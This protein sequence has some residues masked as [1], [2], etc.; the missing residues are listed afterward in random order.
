MTK[1]EIKRNMAAVANAIANQRLEGVEPSRA[2]VFDLTRAAHGEIPV[3]VV[4]ANINKR[5]ADAKVRQQRP[6]L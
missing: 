4:L 1:L 3:D 5:I 2:V 6:L